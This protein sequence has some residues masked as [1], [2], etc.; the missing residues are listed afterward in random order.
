MILLFII[1]TLM[2]S[3][4]TCQN[5]AKCQYWRVY[6]NCSICDNIINIGDDDYCICYYPFTSN[7]SRLQEEC[8]IFCNTPVF[9]C[10]GAHPTEEACFGNGICRSQDNCTCFDNWEGVNWALYTGDDEAMRIMVGRIVEN[11]ERLEAK[12]LLFPE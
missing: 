5:G 8:P 12:N 10:W 3:W 6:K 2:C 4:S 11:M 1:K 9:T 7:V